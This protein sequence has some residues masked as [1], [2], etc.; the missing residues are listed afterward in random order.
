M[1]W[2]DIGVLVIVAIATFIGLK[3]GII[4]AALSLLGLA[5]G[6]VLAG[7]YYAPLAEQLTFLPQE[8]LANGVAFAI[9]L[10][11]VMLI[12]G[13]LASLLKWAVSIVML[14]WLNHLGGAVFGA[15]LGVLLSGT[16]LTL[17]VNFLGTPEI[18]TQS[19]LATILIDRFP[20]VLALLPA[21]FEG[22]RSLFR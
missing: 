21:E 15:F 19:N 13:I 16:L 10:T 1:N 2:L 4:K 20:V 22:I 12:T 11:V 8:G 14:G 9:I 5:L 6:I 7:R 3:I 17:W 18:A